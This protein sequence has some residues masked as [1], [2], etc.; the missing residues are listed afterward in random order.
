MQQRILMQRVTNAPPAARRLN[1]VGQRS[2]PRWAIPS[3]ILLVTMSFLLYMESSEAQTMATT[4]VLKYTPPATTFRQGIQPAE[5][6]SF[7]TCNASLQ[8][9]QFRR[10]QGDILQSFRTTLMRE[11]IA[12][13]HQEENIGTQPSFQEVAVPG[14][15]HAYVVSFAENIVGL[16]RPHTRMLIVAGN[17]A[18]IVDAS[19]GTAQSWQMVMPD[20]N[21]MAATLHVEASRAPATLTASAGRSVA[22]LYQGIKPKYMATMYNVIGSGYYQNALHFYLLAPDG[23]FYRAYDRLDVPGGA[24]ANFDFDAA[25]RNDPE[26]FGHYTID[27]G[28]LILATEGRNPQTIVSHTPADR[29]LVIESVTYQKK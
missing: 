20:L 13:M 28:K 29:T 6:Y 21:Q 3:A 26:N 19:A 9:Y 25:E 8:V 15:E 24:I 12:P 11:W 22:G 27:N 2:P 18:A 5:D 10:F 16:P 17:E 4:H 1:R 14:A 23:R 7:T